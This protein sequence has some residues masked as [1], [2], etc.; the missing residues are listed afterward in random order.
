METEHTGDIGEQEAT[1]RANAIDQA[2]AAAASNAAGENQPSQE[3]SRAVLRSNAAGFLYVRAID[4]KRRTISFLSPC[5]PPLPSRVL[6]MGSIK[7]YDE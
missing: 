5:N 3:F 1:A 6:I 7:F 2:A 4:W